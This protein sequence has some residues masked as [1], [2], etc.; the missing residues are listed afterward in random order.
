M[1]SKKNPVSR[2][3][4][5]M[6]MTAVCKALSEDKFKEGGHR[7]QLTPGVFE[8]DTCIRIKGTIKVLEDT[9]AFDAYTPPLAE[10]LLVVLREFIED[11]SILDRLPQALRKAHN[12]GDEKRKKELGEAGITTVVDTFKK[13]ILAER[14]KQP[15]KGAIIPNLKVEGI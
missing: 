5:A 12:M 3:L 9:T 2:P 7:D 14:G 15:K 10:A 13:K 1:A 6:E 4:T 8:V 11:D